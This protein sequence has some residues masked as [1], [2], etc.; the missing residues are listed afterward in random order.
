MQMTLG[1]WIQLG[2]SMEVLS[3]DTH[4]GSFEIHGPGP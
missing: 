2:Y 1:K 4:V 3:R